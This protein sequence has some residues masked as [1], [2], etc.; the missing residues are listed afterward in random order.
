MINF[1]LRYN[2]EKIK[3]EFKLYNKFFSQINLSLHTHSTVK[4][5]NKN[6]QRDNKKYAKHVL[7]KF[8]TNIILYFCAKCIR[9]ND[10]SYRKSIIG[11]NHRVQSNTVVTKQKRI[12]HVM[13]SCPCPIK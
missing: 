13:S 5:R 11:V 6:I 2:L 4:D 9:Q 12:S 1:C 8:K 7:L 10:R 3:T